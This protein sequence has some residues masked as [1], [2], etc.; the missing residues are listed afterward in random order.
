MTGL[1]GGWQQGGHAV[2]ARRKP[3]SFSNPWLVN[4]S[5]LQFSAT[6][7]TTFF[8]A[9]DFI[10]ASISRVTVTLT[11]AR[12]GRWDMTSSENLPA[13]DTSHDDMVQ[14]ARCI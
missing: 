7:R 11:P 3:Y 8:G 4:F 9:P 5:V 12:P 10:S 13:L 1:L 14:D 6:M 2:L